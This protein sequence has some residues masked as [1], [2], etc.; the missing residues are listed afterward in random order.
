[1]RKVEILESSREL[2]VREKLNIK[3]GENTSLDEALGNTIESGA[4]TLCVNVNGYAVLKIH[5]DKPDQTGK[6]ER[7]ALAILLEDGCY[8]TA[9][10]TFIE[11]FREIWDTMTEDGNTSPVGIAVRRGESKNYKGKY[12]ITCNIL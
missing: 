1:M 11:R 4:D 3:M 10:Q 8:I 5:L 12:F 2:T 9:S 7:D 6:T